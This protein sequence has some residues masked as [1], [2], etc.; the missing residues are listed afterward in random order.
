[1]MY[2]KPI[3]IQ[4]QDAETEEWTD[5]LELH[6]RVNKTGGGVTLNAG[7][8]QYQVRLT[9]EM[10]YCEP[11]E[12]IAYSVQPYRIVYRGRHFK[13]LDYDDYME[14]HLTVKMVGELYE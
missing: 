4:T 13:V 5:A 11:L 10:R 9:F 7:A 6:A 12:K 3:T 2:D 1:M 14:R 8:D